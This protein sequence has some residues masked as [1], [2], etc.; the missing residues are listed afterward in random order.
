MKNWFMQMILSVAE[1]FEGMLVFS[2]KVN[3]NLTEAQA[4]FKS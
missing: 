3:F 4:L 2:K 1:E